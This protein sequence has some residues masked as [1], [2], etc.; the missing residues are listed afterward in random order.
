M[1]SKKSSATKQRTRKTV[2]FRIKGPRRALVKDYIPL[3][4]GSV[5]QRYFGGAD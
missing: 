3:L 1:C 5:T 4:D 2:A